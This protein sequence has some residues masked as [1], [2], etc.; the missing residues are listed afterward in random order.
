MHIIH[1]ESVKFSPHD[2][3]PDL[4]REEWLRRVLLSGE[5]SGIAQHLAL[6]SHFASGGSGV[7][8][9]SVRDL[10]RITGWSR[11]AIAEHLALLDPIASV[12]WGAGRAK[13]AFILSYADDADRQDFVEVI[14]A[15]SK[16]ELRL[17]AIAEFGHVCSHCDQPGTEDVGPDDRPWCLDRIIPGKVGGE[18]VANNVTLSCWA[19]NARRGANPIEQRIFSLA[20]WRDLRSEW[21]DVGA[22]AA[23]VCCG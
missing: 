13:S 3:Q 11:T 7:L 6:A 15:E 10:Q 19:C 22:T 2:P 18:Y 17:A 16:S 8:R 1:A 9:A 20:D 23:E 5:V 21:R 12:V 14:T 4:T